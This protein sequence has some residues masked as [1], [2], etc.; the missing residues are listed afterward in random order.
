[1]V[2]SIEAREEARADSI[3]QV[4]QKKEHADM[5]FVHVNAVERTWLRYIK[6]GTDT[7]EYLL[8]EG[9][10]LDIKADSTLYFLV[11]NAAGVE[12]TINGN[13]KGLIG[14][15]GQVISYLKITRNGI[16]G[17][18]IKDM[19]SRDKKSETSNIN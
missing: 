14:K 1:V 2:Q 11:G 9:N 18:R 8:Q 15:K 7:T 5:V 10:K 19:S 16:E 3:K 17:Q 12:F 13:P 6:D 4:M